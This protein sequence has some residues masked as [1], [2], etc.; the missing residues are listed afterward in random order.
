MMSFYKFF[1]KQETHTLSSH[2]LES[3][4]IT[5]IESSLRMLSN[6]EKLFLCNPPNHK[7]CPKLLNSLQVS[8]LR[9]Q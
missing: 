5:L 3:V 1:H 2:I 9:D 4:L 7:P 6:P 8:L